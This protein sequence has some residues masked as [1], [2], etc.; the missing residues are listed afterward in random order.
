MA[1]LSA[2][3]AVFGGSFE[4]HLVSTFDAGHGG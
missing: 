1:V 4:Q 2:F 3:L